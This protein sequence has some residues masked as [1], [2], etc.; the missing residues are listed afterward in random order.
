MCANNAG[1]VTNNLNCWMQIKLLLD[2]VLL[3]NVG[4]GTGYVLY[5]I[6]KYK[7]SGVIIVYQSLV[8]PHCVL[9]LQSIYAS[10]LEFITLL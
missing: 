5:V 9:P 1:K 7:T 6:I 2:S 8:C 4:P 3:T 10:F